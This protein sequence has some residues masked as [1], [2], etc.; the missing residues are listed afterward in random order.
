MSDRPS[1]FWRCSKGCGCGA[2]Q[3]DKC[4]DKVRYVNRGWELTFK[5][6]Q[7]MDRQDI[8]ISLVGNVHPRDLSEWVH[9]IAVKS[10]CKR[11]DIPYVEKLL[12]TDTKNTC[13]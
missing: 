8:E 2:Q 9:E 11:W 4:Q 7:T 6:L 12:E 3:V 5:L 1:W 13:E 10:M